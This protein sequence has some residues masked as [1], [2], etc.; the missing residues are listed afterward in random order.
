MRKSDK[1][2]NIAEANRL[3]EEAFMREREMMGIASPSKEYTDE[4]SSAAQ[5]AAIAINMKKKG[6]E[7]KNEEMGSENQ[8]FNVEAAIDEIIEN[9]IKGGIESLT[10]REA[11]IL[12]EADN[13]S[14]I[15]TCDLRVEESPYY[16][17]QTWDSPAEGSDGILDFDIEKGSFLVFEGDNEKEIEVPGEQ[18][19]KLETVLNDIINDSDT[20]N[21]YF[22]DDDEPDYDE[23]D[24]RER[25][26]SRFDE[27]INEIKKITK[28]LL[29]E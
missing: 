25:Y 17:A 13:F 4:A 12:F 6:I 3:A 20:L 5:Q 19:K 15:V 14:L 23:D 26:R 29:G 11:E 16:V 22:D 8:S 9:S 1:K 10:S 28:R 24:A 7:P 18:L 2:A 27:E 21:R